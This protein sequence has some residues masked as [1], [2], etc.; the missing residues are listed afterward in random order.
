MN[1]EKLQEFLEAVGRWKSGIASENDSVFI[2]NVIQTCRVN[3]WR[4]NQVSVSGYV[5]GTVNL[6]FQTAEQA[7]SF[8]AQLQLNT[9]PKPPAT[10]ASLS[11]RF[12]L[13]TE[14]SVN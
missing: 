11:R 10:Q 14:L 8:L 5:I 2:Q 7:Q 6:V 1:E 4:S 12:F 9:P 13:S 3:F